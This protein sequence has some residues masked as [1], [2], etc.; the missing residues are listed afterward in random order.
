M[1]RGS[2][3]DLSGSGDELMPAQCPRA[4]HPIA[5]APLPVHFMTADLCPS[6]S[7]QDVVSFGAMEGAEGEDDAILVEASA[8]E[9]WSNSPLD[10]TAPHSSYAGDLHY[11]EV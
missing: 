7:T 9:E 11:S 2:N 6:P 3:L 1:Q 10:Y 5:E 8:R 4:P